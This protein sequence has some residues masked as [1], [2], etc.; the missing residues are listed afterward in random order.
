MWLLLCTDPGILFS[1]LKAKVGL[2]VPDPVLGPSQGEMPHPVGSCAL[3]A[4]DG[5]SLAQEQDFWGSLVPSVS[6]WEHYATARGWRC[7]PRAPSWKEGGKGEL[8]TSL[9]SFQGDTILPT[10]GGA[11][12]ECSLLILTHPQAGAGFSLPL[13]DFKEVFCLFFFSSR[14][15]VHSRREAGNAGEDEDGVLGYP[16]PPMG[17]GVN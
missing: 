7:D 1:H 9:D 17:T 13:L 14:E 15:R 5:G 2:A 10:P 4:H 12:A 6:L 11:D 8:V 16:N 3:P